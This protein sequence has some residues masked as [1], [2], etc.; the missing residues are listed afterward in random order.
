MDAAQ[1][2]PL[3][4]GRLK[5]LR[6]RVLSGFPADDGADLVAALRSVLIGE[7]FS[8]S[9]LRR[10][11]Q[12]LVFVSDGFL[13][14]T[15]F[16]REEA[17]GRELG[18]LMRDDTDQDQ[19]RAAREEVQDGRAATA[20]IRCYRPDGSL[21]WNEQRHYPVKD[22][23]GRV[24]HAVVVQRDVTDLIN[25]RS[26]NEV[27]RQFASSLG[28][29]GVFFSYGAILDMGGRARLVW[30]QDGVGAVLGHAP[31]ALR[32]GD[33]LELIVPKD[34]AGASERLRALR[35]D[36][37]SRRD[38]YRMHGADGRVRWVEDFA[39]VSWRADEARLVAVHGVVRDVTSETLGRHEVGAVDALTGLATERVLD[40]RLEQA[41]RQARRHGGVAALVL[42]ELDHFDFAHD[43]FRP[44]RAERFVREAT[45]SLQ[46][47]LRRSDTLA[48][49]RP[50]CFAVVLPD[51]VD[52]QAAVPVVEK[53]LAW[54]ARPFQDGTLRV[55]LAASA[56]VAVAPTDGRRTDALRDAAEAA[57][58]RARAGGG[59]R[60]AFA[61]LAL[62]QAADARVRFERELR[63]AFVED[64]LVLHFQPRVRLDDGRHQ[65]VEALVRWRH[66]ERGLL[67]PHEFLPALYRAQLGDTLFEWVLE[68]A[69][70]Q[71]A[72][73]RDQGMPRRVSVNVGPAL[74]ERND[75]GEVVRGALERWDLHPGLLELELHEATGVRALERGAEQLAAVRRYGVTVALD[76][77]GVVATDFAQLRKLP[78][79]ALKIDRS[80]V[81]RVGDGAD[82][83][84]VALLRAMVDIGHGLGL[85]V[86]AEG[87]ETAAQRA[88]VADMAVHEGQGFLFSQALPGDLV[89]ASGRAT[90]AHAP[91]TRKAVG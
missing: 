76:D 50:G 16:R 24:A 44:S 4:D 37:G 15:G 73:W 55:E 35:D 36:G 22:V 63:A 78:I 48:L 27:A 61:D 12:P 6:E 56:G 64:Q 71:A 23:R 53:L 9:D 2:P 82:P 58:Q 33:L 72:A 10:V 14:L 11:G 62:D 25:A 43:V 83:A 29:D 67:L 60:F 30:V 7:S 1:H 46:R 51:L 65:A 41:A 66:P 45:R 75:F 40:D 3:A 49:A 68:H 54:V 59:S 17:L 70:A 13:A 8:V 79:D 89:A 32:G 26:A 19:A 39:A 5:A 84:D 69:V 20:L 90:L 42:L 21:F 47:A 85:T 81:A 86:V 77:F 80:F 31:E 38:R 87:I 18:F 88:R 74:L 91:G 52:P 34:R 28:G 57:L